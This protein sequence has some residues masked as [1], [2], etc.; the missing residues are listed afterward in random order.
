MAPVL[1]RFDAWF[2]NVFIRGQGG[3]LD[4][5]VNDDIGRTTGRITAIGNSRPGVIVNGVYPDWSRY[6]A[7]IVDL[8][9]DGESPG[10]LRVRVHDQLH[11]SF[12]RRPDD[13]YNHWFDLEPGLQQVR[14]PLADIVAAPERREMDLSRMEGVGVF[15]ARNNDGKRFEVVEIRLE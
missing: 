3:R 9:L 15:A 4:R 14:I 2:N 6:S 1:L 5:I 11:R 12:R 13:R 7:L 10:Q 8:Y